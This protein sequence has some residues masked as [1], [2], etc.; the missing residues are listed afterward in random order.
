MSDKSATE[1]ASPDAAEI[2]V[3]T[4]TILVGGFAFIVLVVMIWLNVAV[5]NRGA[6]TTTCVENAQ[7]S[8]NK[9]A[10]DGDCEDDTHTEEHSFKEDEFYTQ[11]Y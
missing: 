10:P 8:I 6:D 2:T 4:R 1:Q 9:T 7:I 3:S 5:L 11:R